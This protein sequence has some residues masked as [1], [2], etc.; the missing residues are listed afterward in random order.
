[1]KLDYFKK[2]MIETTRFYQLPKILL[3]RDYFQTLTLSAKMVYALLLDRMELSRKNGWQDEDGTIFC[4]FKNS[5][6]ATLLGITERTVT[7]HLNKLKKFG[8]IKTVKQANKPDKIYL[9]N[10][11]KQIAKLDSE[12]KN[13]V[14]ENEFF[15]DAAIQQFRFLLVPQFLLEEKLFK[16]LSL[17]AR[18]A[19]SLL[20][21]K[22]RYADTKKQ[23][24]L[25]GNIYINYSYEQLCQD[26]NISYRSFLRIMKELTCYKLPC[27]F[28][29]NITVSLIEVQKEKFS[30][31]NKIYLKNIYDIN[32]VISNSNKEVDPSKTA[33]QAEVT[34]IPVVE[35]NDSLQNEPVDSNF[36][37]QNIKISLRNMEQTFCH[38]REKPSLYGEKNLAK[39]E[40]TFCHNRENEQK[41]VNKFSPEKTICHSGTDKLAQWNRHFGTCNTIILSNNTEYYNTKIDDYYN[42]QTKKA[43]V[44][45]IVSDIENFTKRY[46]LE[47]RPVVKTCVE[48][49][50]KIRN[51]SDNELIFGL[52]REKVFKFLSQI[53]RKEIFKVMDRCQKY[54]KGIANLE[55][56]FFHAL[57][58]QAKCQ[59]QA[60]PLSM[61]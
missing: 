13:S 20:F 60:L 48:V 17:S 49:L 9:K 4:Y 10:F 51:L 42:H 31:R 12:H 52:S 38:N 7:R 46:H 30:G 61:T 25:Q 18:I 28:F 33:Q 27:S 50:R 47:K 3:E 24:D 2:G 56:Y 11:L 39:M 16:N 23:I 32:K 41:N 37:D 8:L 58:N 34:L 53:T 19:Y 35:S 45:N 14:N 57:I 29:S 43:K 22:T 59:T 40:Q 6:I 15:T 1:M 44:I 54:I 26:L 5:E 21:E 36:A 55:N